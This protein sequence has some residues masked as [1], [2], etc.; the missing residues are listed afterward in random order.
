MHVTIEQGEPTVVTGVRCDLD[1]TVRRVH[2]QPLGDR[3]EEPW[4]R[5]A[6]EIAGLAHK[7]IG[8][9]K[10]EGLERKVLGLGVEV[11]GHVNRGVVYMGDHAGYHAYNEPVALAAEVNRHL[12]RLGTGRLIIVVDNDVDL[13]A[14]REAYTHGEPEG[15]GPIARSMDALHRA[16]WAPRADALPARLPAHVGMARAV[17]LMAQAAGEDDPLGWLAMLQQ[18]ELCVRRVAAAHRA[19]QDADEAEYL[20]R[21]TQE[22]LAAARHRLET[23]G[24]PAATASPVSRTPTSVEAR[25]ATTRQ[26]DDRDRGR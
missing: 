18:L 17:R 12:E 6:H 4:L 1:G 9:W 8:E 21:Q 7:L 15:R 13:I 19:R 24:A 25:P 22:G 14:L 3:G 2:P 26:H 23:A 11:P 20:T 10:S 5:L 16:A